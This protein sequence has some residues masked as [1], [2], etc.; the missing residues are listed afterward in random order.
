MILPDRCSLQS[1]EHK[2]QLNKIKARNQTKP[3]E[4]QA[5]AMQRN[6]SSK[7][8][9][10]KSKISLDKREYPMNPVGIKLF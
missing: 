5:A 6:T 10:V 7:T 3:S 2:L 1:I 9:F 8:Q 4:G